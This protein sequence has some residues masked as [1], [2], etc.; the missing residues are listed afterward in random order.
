MLCTR[1]YNTSNRRCAP[2]PPE[3][4]AKGLEPYNPFL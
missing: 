2:S 4:E 1:R 3:L